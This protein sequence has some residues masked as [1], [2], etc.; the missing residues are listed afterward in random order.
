GPQLLVRATRVLLNY[1]VRRR[2]D[3]PRRAVVLL[4]LDDLRPGEVPREIE[5]VVHLGAA[6]PVDRLVVIADDAQVSVLL[7]EQAQQLVLRRVRV[8]ELVD[9]DVAE[10]RRVSLRGLRV[11]AEQLD[12]PDDQIAEIDGAGRLQ[13]SL[14]PLV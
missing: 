7:R 12:D 4:Q 2:Q 14:I 10:P 9:E 6:P 11:L 8:L 5:D 13:R 3:A 1:G